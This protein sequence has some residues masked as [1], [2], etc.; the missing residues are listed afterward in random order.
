MLIHLV[1]ILKFLINHH[2]KLLF[3][4]KH[5]S[6]GGNDINLVFSFFAFFSDSVGWIIKWLLVFLL[7]GDLGGVNVC[8]LDYGVFEG[9][10]LVSPEKLVDCWWE[11]QIVKLSFMELD[12]E[13]VCNDWREVCQHVVEQ[14]MV[15]FFQPIVKFCFLNIEFKADNVQDF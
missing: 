12:V 7:R 2:L 9:D 10:V 8:G 13:S 1:L 11:S 5:R 15:I 3:V 4:E 14:I 6:I